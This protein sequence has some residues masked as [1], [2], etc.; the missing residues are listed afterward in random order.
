MRK[1]LALLPIFLL[2][3]NLAACAGGPVETTAPQTTTGAPAEPNDMTNGCTPSYRIDSYEEYVKFVGVAD[4]PEKFVEY[5]AISQFGKFVSFVRLSNEYEGD[6]S[7]YMYEL[8]DESGIEVVLYVECGRNGPDTE[9]LPLIDAVNI[10]NMR[11][12][13][14]GEKGR[15]V[16]K[17]VEYTYIEGRLHTISWE[18][19]GRVFVLTSDSFGD[20]P[21]G[22]NT[23]VE[24]LMDT[25]NT[26]MVIASVSVLVEKR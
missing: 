2:L 10:N 14:A 17:G 3:L 13:T 19:N 24:E 18:G 11:R 22:T 8:V 23:L 25:S 9:E 5:K 16:H 7:H 1:K 26:E 4:L 15:Y 12:L 6:Y 20:Y 21:V